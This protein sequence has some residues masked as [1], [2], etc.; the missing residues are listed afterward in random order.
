M[1]PLTPPPAPRLLPGHEER[2]GTVKMQ[3]PHSGHSYSPAQEPCSHAPPA[4]EPAAAALSAL[5]LAS[6][7]STKGSLS[8]PQKRSPPTMKVGAPK[9]PSS[10]A[11]AVLACLRQQRHQVR[12]NVASP[13]SKDAQAV[14]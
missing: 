10:A 11:S 8:C 12:A 3:V 14:L 1:V 5:A 9:T 13:V 6:A 2:I 7:R 4:G